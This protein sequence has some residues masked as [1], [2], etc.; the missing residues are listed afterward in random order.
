M[1]VSVKPTPTNQGNANL[2]AAI[3]AIGSAAL[4]FPTPQQ[5]TSP[6]DCQSDPIGCGEAANNSPN[7]APNCK[8]P[9]D[10]VAYCQRIMGNTPGVASSCSPNMD[11]TGHASG[12][13]CTCWNGSSV[14]DIASSAIIGIGESA[15]FA[16]VESIPL[17]AKAL[18]AIAKISNVQ[19]LAWAGT[20]LKVGDHLLAHGAKLGK[21]DNPFCPN[22]NFVVVDPA[23]AEQMLG[24]L[25]VL[26]R[27][28]AWLW[29]NRGNENGLTLV[30]VTTLCSAA[31]ETVPCIIFFFNCPLLSL[32][33]WRPK[34]VLA[35]HRMR[36]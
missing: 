36:P 6:T 33:Y 16:W 9:K 2:L 24:V 8:D 15:C 35:V 19:A 10:C 20:V 26:I 11:S 1:K 29:C 30:L 25:N 7:R 3:E 32:V 5:Q 21:C 17:G 34:V 28:I 18:Q 31:K 4:A 23:K 12:S 22:H 14:V 27:G 13:V